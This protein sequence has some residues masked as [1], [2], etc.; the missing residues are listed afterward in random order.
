MVEIGGGE[1]RMEDSITEH[2][3]P[4][5]PEATGDSDVVDR[6]VIAGPGVHRT[7][8]AFDERRNFP[9]RKAR[10][11]FEQHVLEHMGDARDLEIL[12]GAAKTHPGLQR[13]DRGTVILE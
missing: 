4:G 9:M 13:D 3:E 6:L 10:C 12:V 5:F 2:I 11:T 1:Q 7:S 8:G